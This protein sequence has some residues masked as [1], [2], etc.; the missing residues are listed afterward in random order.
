MP[1]LSAWCCFFPRDR[2]TSARNP[3]SKRHRQADA[4]TGNESR[5]KLLSLPQVKPGNEQ[6]PCAAF[7]GRWQMPRLMLAFCCKC[8]CL[9]LLPVV[10]LLTSQ[11]AQ[12]ALQ[13]KRERKCCVDKHKPEADCGTHS[14]CGIHGKQLLLHISK[15]CACRK[16]DQRKFFFASVCDIPFMPPLKKR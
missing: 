8:C 12:L 2:E 7:A 1:C 14:E 16:L 3:D 6:T 11:S 13:V 15:T 5:E 10:L 4:G 9:F